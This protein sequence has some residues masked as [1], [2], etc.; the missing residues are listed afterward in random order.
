HLHGGGEESLTERAEGFDR[1]MRLHALPLWATLGVDADAGFRE[2]I[3][4]DGTPAAAFRRARVQA[5][6]AWV[7]AVAGQAGWDGPW[8]RLV[9]DGLDR[10][11]ATNRRPDGLYRTRV[12]AAG[13]TLDDAASLYDQAFSLL[14]FAAAA[15]AGVDTDRMIARAHDLRAAL[16]TLALPGG[17]W[18]EDAG[19]P[20]QANAHMHLLEA[21]L[22]WEALEPGEAWTV[23]AD[24]I[25][26]LARRWF[27]D[28]ED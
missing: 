6:Q 27:I 20:H 5:R 26:S 13:E 8:R 21:C 15:E 4:R 22:A 10:F 24:E 3:G 1:W 19:H 14:A 17:G 16:A 9:R 2:A 7:Y 18:R 23:M 11:E 25:V 12:S 28:A